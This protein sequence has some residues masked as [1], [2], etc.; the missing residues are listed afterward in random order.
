M[1]QRKHYF[2]LVMI[3]A[4]GALVRLW[5]L[6]V[7]SL[8]LDEAQSVWQASHSLD[9]I[10]QYMLKNVH[11]PLHNSLLYMWLRFVGT[12][13]QSVRLLAAIPGILTLPV[14]YLLSKELVN[15]EASLLATFLAAFS[16]FWIW[17]SREIRMYSLLAFLTTVSYYLYLKILRSGKTR[18]LILYTLVNTVGMY[19]HYYFAFPLAVQGIFF[20]FFSRHI[21]NEKFSRA[22][23]FVRFMTSAFITYMAFLPW[24]RALLYAEN[25]AAYAPVLDKPSP[26][27]IFLSF[28][29]FTLGFQSPV[30]TSL[31]MGFWPLVILLGFVFLTKRKNPF[32]PEVY[33]MT[34]GIL[35][36]IL[37]T[38]AVSYLYKPIYLTRYLTPATP[39]YYTFLAWFLYQFKGFY[40]YALGT[41][42]GAL[43]VLSLYNQTFHPD[44][45]VREDYRAASQ[46]INENA[47]MRDI[48]LV[49]PPFN[50]Y[51]VQYYYTGLARVVT[52][53]I[54]DERTGSIPQVSEERLDRD[55]KS[56]KPGHRRMFVLISSNLEGMDVV[57]E[58]FDMRYTK[59]DKQEFSKD[60]WVHVYQAEYT[61][62]P[63][64]EEGAPSEIVPA[65]TVVAE[66]P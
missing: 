17:Y 64:Q 53:P 15:R 14:I 12:D 23:V 7:E 54:W 2:I 45:P 25:S 8:R 42:F 13:E 61:D 29:E 59:L 58:Y 44:N 22:T 51:P 63:G 5:N 39:L 47:E 9:F 4:L 55:V 6:N 36:P 28:F 41:A 34:M 62:E 46:Y 37:V 31:L 3:I 35:L 48:V 20:V 16:P 11:L 1:S 24:L 19:T 10:Y 52:M 66:N 57:Q 60:L 43:V 30:F 21:I 32:T 56:V 18:Y 26:F 65:K 27:N 40:R 38:F 49:S 33:L 50:I